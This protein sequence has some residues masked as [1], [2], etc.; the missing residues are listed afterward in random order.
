MRSAFG[1][2]G[3]SFGR[4]EQQLVTPDTQLCNPSTVQ[5]LLF[6]KVVICAAHTNAASLC[7]PPLCVYLLYPAH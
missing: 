2:L 7:I 4:F 1:L 6:G 5:K 3:I